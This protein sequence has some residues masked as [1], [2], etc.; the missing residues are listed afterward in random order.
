MQVAAVA[1][2]IRVR[3]YCAAPLV[4]FVAVWQFLSILLGQDILPRPAEVV[5]LWATHALDD[6]VIR[7]QGGGN[8]GF[9][10]HAALTMARV[11]G[12]VAI[13][14]AT[15]IV[16]AGV[17]FQ[18]SSW[19]R[20]IEPLLESLRVI[21]PLILIPIVL[22][23]LGPTEPAQVV[24]C[25]VYA[26]MSMMVHTLNALRNVPGSYW[27]IAHMHH[28]SRW[29]TLQTVA[30]PAVLPELLGGIRISLALGLGIVI[31][32]E[33]L[34]A[35]DGIG[36]V[37]KFTLSFARV[38]LLLVGLVWAALIGVLFDQVISQ[39]LMRRNRWRG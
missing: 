12:G 8:Y 36:R 32:S 17:L 27:V 10:P 14:T 4:A 16:L 22:V 24:V 35:P 28:A 25:A 20:G 15:G 3:A 18:W 21:P 34:G 30:L 9:L 13:G 11:A 39:A 33:Y 19:R 37:L 5:Q 7:S 38:D 6:A 1:R 31:V 26:A 23:L 2:V 29:Q